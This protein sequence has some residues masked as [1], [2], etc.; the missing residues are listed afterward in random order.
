[1]TFKQYIVFML[2]GTVSALISWLIVF[3]VIDPVSAGLPSK[4]AFFTTFFIS[5]IGFLTI[6]G[7]ILRVFVFDKMGVVSRQATHAF[8]QAFFLSSILLCTL[9]LSALDF[10][11][12]WSILLIVMFFAFLE[13]FLETSNRRS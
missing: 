5:S 6:L 9:I 1:M 2:I 11:R 12:W 10:L 4:I 3:M 8:R 13:A 7:T